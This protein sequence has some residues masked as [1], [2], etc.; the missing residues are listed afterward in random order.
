MNVEPHFMCAFLAANTAMQL[1]DILPE[2]DLIED[3][4]GIILIQF[5][6]LSHMMEGKHYGTNKLNDF[7]L[8]LQE[9]KAQI[10]RIRGVGE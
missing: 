3:L 9:L 6:I 4:R 10:H 7:M 5:D 2:S 8:C 1:I